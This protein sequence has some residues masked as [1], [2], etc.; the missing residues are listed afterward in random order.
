M[1]CTIGL[2]ALFQT[3]QIIIRKLQQFFKFLILNIIVMSSWEKICSKMISSRMKN[4]FNVMS[5]VVLQEKIEKQRKH[6]RP[7]KIKNCKSNS[8]YYICPLPLNKIK[9]PQ[10]E[11]F[12]CHQERFCKIDDNTHNNPFIV[13]FI[14]KFLIEFFY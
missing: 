3:I 10:L 14:L 12:P 9:E 7:Q 13:M 1:K 11:S 2:N 5:N 4:W 6:W 8:I